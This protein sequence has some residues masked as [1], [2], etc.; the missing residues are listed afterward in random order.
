MDLLLDAVDLIILL[1]NICELSLE[2]IIELVRREQKFAVIQGLL[3]II[4]FRLD[5]TICVLLPHV[6]VIILFK[7]DL[8]LTLE[9]LKIIEE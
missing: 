2:A 9:F 6:E 7:E 5:L 1:S 8:A 4:D 3:L